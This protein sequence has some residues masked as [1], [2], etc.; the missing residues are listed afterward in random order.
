MISLAQ[1]N[2]EHS[3]LSKEY[4]CRTSGALHLEKETLRKMQEATMDHLRRDYTF[5]RYTE[6]IQYSVQFLNILSINY[7]A[8]HSLLL[9]PKPSNIIP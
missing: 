9:T 6:P 1:K 7:L 5:K 4:S 2:E 3:R 8:A